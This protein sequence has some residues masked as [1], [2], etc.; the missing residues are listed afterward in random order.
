MSDG[1]ATTAHRLRKPTVFMFSGQGS[2]YYQ[3]GKELYDNHSRF[4]YWMAHCDEIVYPLVRTSLIDVLYQRETRTKP[5][6]QI[7][8]TNPA[9]LSIEYSLACV[10]M[11]MDI[12][13]DFLLGYSLG[14]IAASVISGVISLE[15]GLELVVGIA[16]LAQ[17][18]T[19]RV[20]MLAIIESPEI[21]A[22]FPGLFQDCWVTGKNFN[23]SF[24]VCGLPHHIQQ[25]QESL[26]QQNIVFQV[27]PVKYGFHTELIDSIEEEYKKLVRGINLSPI[28]IPIVSSSKAEIIQEVN[29]DYLWGVIRYRV[30][31]QKTVERMLRR[32]D[33]VLIDVGPSGTMSTF[34][35]YL[36]PADSQSFA[37]QV[38]NQFGRDLESIEKLRDM[39]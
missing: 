2:Q 34:V 20:G 32:G 13:P 16:R 23:R 21:V 9:L 18:R 38:I 26:K 28:G 14:E 37:L 11:E 31:F 5:F 36:L 19:R 8:Y 3:M 33:Y 4:R 22:E 35:K 17:A 30:D 25:L 6:D 39:L 29:E 1:R 7:L 10:L 24:V 15:D 27:L 12:H